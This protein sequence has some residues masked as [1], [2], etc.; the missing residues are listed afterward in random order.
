MRRKRTKICRLQ[1]VFSL[2]Y[3]CPMF[4]LVLQLTKSLPCEADWIGKRKSEAEGGWRMEVQKGAS[5][6]VKRQRKSGKKYNG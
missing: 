4:C 5:R 6:P 2:G 3:D 1:I